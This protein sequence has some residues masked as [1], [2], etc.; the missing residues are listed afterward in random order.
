MKEHSDFET[1]AC[2]LLYTVVGFSLWGSILDSSGYNSIISFILIFSYIALGCF[3]A[4]YIISFQRKAP[5][6]F[7]KAYFFTKRS[8]SIYNRYI[9]LGTH[10]RN[11]K[12]G[13][14]ISQDAISDAIAEYYHN[15]GGLCGMSGIYPSLPLSIASDEEVPFNISYCLNYPFTSINLQRLQLEHP[16]RI[17]LETH[18]H[19]VIK[20]ITLPA[21]LSSLSVFISYCANL[22]KITIPSSTPIKIST[23]GLSIPISQVSPDFSIFVPNNLLSHYQNSYSHI[24]VEYTDNTKG[25]LRFLPIEQKGSSNVSN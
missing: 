23:D 12:H 1:F 16:M 19:P 7:N 15:S 18:Y 3:L 13:K 5:G 14:K 10:P 24:I 8:Y 20:E 25:T 21:N 9:V 2:I 6:I 11:K 4:W 17:N 22:S